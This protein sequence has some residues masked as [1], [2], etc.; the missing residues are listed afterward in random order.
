MSHKLK[1]D[2]PYGF[3]PD[4]PVHDAFL[5]DCVRDT[6]FRRLLSIDPAL[7]ER[8]AEC[9]TRAVVMAA[10]AMDGMR[11]TGEVLAYEGTYGVGYLSAAF[12]AHGA[13]PSLL[14]LIEEDAQRHMDDLRA[15][16][17]A[18]VRL[19]RENVESVVRTGKRTRIP[20]GLPSEMIDSR[21]GVF[22]TIKKDG[23]LRGCIGTIQPVRRNVAAEILENS[24]SAALHDAR[25]DPVAPEE[26]GG[27]TY[28][29]D[30][31]MP[32]EPAAGLEELDPGR[33]GVIV[34]CGARR[35][36]LLP[37]LDGVDSAEE[38]VRI[39]REKGGIGAEEPYALERFEVVRHV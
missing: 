25:F 21:A 14:P 32:P 1:E 18:W 10:G 35:G 34:S 9:G 36:L 13:A 29:V 15:G 27:L 2:G 37:H 8:A 38:Q 16:E 31:L 20:D 26:L 22:V 6:D 39:A 4:G 23:A 30:V 33:F 7:C 28:S 11:V 19:A 17:D 3:A 5:Q 12:A 24:V